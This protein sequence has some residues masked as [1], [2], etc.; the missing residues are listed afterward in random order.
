MEHSLRNIVLYATPWPMTIS[1][2]L[3]SFKQSPFGEW[4][5]KPQRACVLL[6]LW[7]MLVWTTASF[8]WLLFPSSKTDQHYH[9][10]TC[11]G[12]GEE[13]AEGSGLPR[14]CG[15]FWKFSGP[16]CAGLGAC[17]LHHPGTPHEGTGGEVEGH[18]IAISL[19]ST[20]PPPHGR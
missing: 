7:K 9:V 19:S 13:S 4:K 10:S 1:Q 16:E 18:I 6:S 2:S 12:E 17:P 3:A 14:L 5:N 11:R 8:D 15:L 20:A